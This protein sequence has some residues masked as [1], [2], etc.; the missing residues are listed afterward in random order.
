MEG[1]YS[2]HR[3]K[4]P[5]EHSTC[6][7]CKNVGH[8]KFQCATYLKKIEGEKNT[9]RDFKSKKAY[10]IWDVPEE[11]SAS[12]TL[13]EEETAKLCL[14]AHTLDS[15]NLSD[16]GESCE[17]Q[18]VYSSSC[19]DSSENMPDYDELHVAFVELQEELKKLARINVDLKRVAKSALEDAY[20]KESEMEK[21]AQIELNENQEGDDMQKAWKMKKGSSN[22]QGPQ[23]RTHGI[24]MQEE[25]NQFEQNNVWNL[26]PKPKDHPNIGTKWVFCN[27]LNESDL[28]I[29]NKA[30]VV[31]QGYNQ[32]ECIDYDETYA[33]VVRLEAIRMLLAYDSIMNFT[34]FQMDVKIA[35]LNS[36]IEEEVYVNQPSSFENFKFPNH[37][38]K[39]KKA[40]FG[41][42]Q[43]LRDWYEHLSS[44]FLEKKV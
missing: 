39:V 2:T 9:S 20:T 10:I 43:A 6:Y 28:I 12:S 30:G 33:P 35:S 21:E 5:K 29:R 8:M 42:K 41:L 40:L 19:S 25:L 37:V 38:F 13:D 7:E 24:S 23:R 17:V 3:S 14:M 32:E 34:L 18:S 1:K 11:E 44:F 22:W 15:T 27:K 4:A 16:Q 26:I 31:A 36:F